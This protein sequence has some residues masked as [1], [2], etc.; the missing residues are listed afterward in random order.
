MR[1]WLLDRYRETTRRLR[2]VERREL[3]ELRRWLGSTNNLVR[4]SALAVL[5]ALIGIV[6]YL[7]NAVEGLSFLLFPALA[8]GGYTLFA[9]PEGTYASPVRF[10]AGLTIGAACGW[11]ALL[12]AGSTVTPVTGPGFRVGPVAAALSVL[13]A[14]TTTWVLSVEEP[15]AYS[16]ALLALLVPPG[17]QA[18]F[19]LSV[20]VSS[21]ILA[22]VF[23]AWRSE[24][25]ERRAAILYGSTDGD[26][27]VLIP[28]RGPTARSTAMLGGRLAAAHDAGKVVLLDVV[29][30]SD[31]ARRE[32]A[33]LDRHAGGTTDGAR[34]NAGPGSEPRAPGR[35]SVGPAEGGE[36]GPLEGDPEVT[37]AVEALEERA[38]EVE[39]RLGV[40]CR[41]AVAAA[42]AG[43]AATVERAA[44]ETGCDLV[45]APFES[46][47]GGL[48]PY[49]Q[50]L[51]DGPID[52]LVHRTQAGDGT[53]ASADVAARSEWRRV[54]VAV[55]GAS[56]VAYSMVDFAVRLAGATGVVSVAHC[57]NEGG[58]R[59]RAE[60][61][62]A[63]LVGPYGGHVETRVARSRIGNFLGSEA[64]EYDL[65]VLGASRDRSAASRLVSP[66]TFERLEGIDADVAIVDRR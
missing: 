50:E 3:G 45:A 4:L 54:L 26:D 13:L 18:T 32:R 23:T 63:D 52:V 30:G 42:G 41:V 66:P 65:V 19:V 12:L 39:T 6:T 8:S 36:G 51:F 15:A 58:D 38:R 56:D 49:L 5:P 2:R 20:L 1:E 47:R 10:V 61:M 7:S 46:R 14:G 57:L 16:T 24:F 43:L 29:E 64:G 34:A 27:R 17:S 35:A 9:D 25:Y 37:A 22:A 55:R 59:R 53:E 33:L 11:A 60:R 62:L 44:R 28:M 31:R 48:A 21:S 40:P